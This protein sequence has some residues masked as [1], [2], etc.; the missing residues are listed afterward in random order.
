[1]ACGLYSCCCCCSW[2]VYRANGYSGSIE[3]DVLVTETGNI[4][5]TDLPKDPELVEQIVG[6]VTADFI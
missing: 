2:P 3:D 4:N 6:G 5:L 1:M